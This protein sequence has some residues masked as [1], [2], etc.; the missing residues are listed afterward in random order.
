MH[1]HTLMLQERVHE[2]YEGAFRRRPLPQHA[3][4]G[5]LPRSSF[6]YSYTARPTLVWTLAQT[7]KPTVLPFS[8]T[9]DFLPQPVYRKADVFLMVPVESIL[10]SY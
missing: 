9:V 7:L 10:I 8:A 4:V 3:G 6:H 1:A 2:R 5:R